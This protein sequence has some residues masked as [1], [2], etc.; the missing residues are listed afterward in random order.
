MTKR[1]VLISAL[2]LLLLLTAC[3]AQLSA[4]DLELVEYVMLAFNNQL[5]A[6]TYGYDASLDL[7]MATAINADGDAL[8]VEPML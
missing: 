4:A 1:R 2:A 7:S 3:Q 5:A 8:I 6:E